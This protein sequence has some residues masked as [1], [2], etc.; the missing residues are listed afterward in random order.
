MLPNAPG[1]AQVPRS[2]SHAWVLPLLYA[3]PVWGILGRLGAIGV[4]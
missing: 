3:R 1:L 2:P 4:E